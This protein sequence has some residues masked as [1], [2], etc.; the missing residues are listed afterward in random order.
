MNL[1]LDNALNSYK[2]GEENIFISY[3][4]LLGGNHSRQTEQTHKTNLGKYISKIMPI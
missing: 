2:K 4:L 3:K 1:F